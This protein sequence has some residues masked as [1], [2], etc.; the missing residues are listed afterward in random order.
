MKNQNNI[1]PQQLFEFLDW[2]IYKI[3]QQYNIEK[4]F[5]DTQNINAFFNRIL[6]WKENANKIALDNIKKDLNSMK[7]IAKE[8]YKNVEKL[9]KKYW[10]K[11]SAWTV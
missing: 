10:E 11:I 9:L 5:A 2:E 6:M 8:A 4:M 7:K 3:K 1:N